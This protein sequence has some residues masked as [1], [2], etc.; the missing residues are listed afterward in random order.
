MSRFETVLVERFFIG[1]D[2]EGIHEADNPQSFDD[3]AALL[4]RLRAENPTVKY[5]MCAIIDA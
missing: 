3:T 4:E 5:A 1:D 2:D